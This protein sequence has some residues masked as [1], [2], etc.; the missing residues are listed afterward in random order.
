MVDPECLLKERML[1][2][3]SVPRRELGTEWLDVDPGRNENCEE[4]AHDLIGTAFNISCTPA[5]K[6]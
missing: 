3:S 6:P 2:D 5:A 4:T 1:P